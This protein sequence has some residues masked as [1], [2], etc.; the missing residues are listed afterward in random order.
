MTLKVVRL[1]GCQSL[2]D[3]RNGV[4]GI[5]A[6]WTGSGTVHDRVT[7]VQGHRVLQHRFSHRKCFVSGIDQPTV[8]LHQDSRS[9]ILLSVPPVGWARCRAAG[10]KDAFIQTVQFLTVGN[11]L[12]NLL[13]VFW[14]FGSL[15]IRLD[16]FVLLIE[17]G[18]IRNQ[19]LHNIHVRQWI[20]LQLLGVIL[21]DFTETGQ[22]VSSSDVHGAGPTDTFSARSSQ[23]QG[24]ILLIFNFQQGVEHHRT[25]VVQIHLEALQTGLVCWLIRVPPVNLEGLQHVP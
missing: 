22:G 6:F 2:F 5:Q 8:C 10:A 16:R 1:I 13:S 3:L 25:T 15:Q 4:T 24:R 18:Q 20:D 19:V 23:R 14:V 9:Q 11:A 12:Y 17:V 21:V 7:S